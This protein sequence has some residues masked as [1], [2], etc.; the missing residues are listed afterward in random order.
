MNNESANK[1]SRDSTGGLV[2]KLQVVKQSNIGSI[3]SEESPLVLR[4]QIEYWTHTAYYSMGTGDKA[5][6]A[7]NWKS[8]KV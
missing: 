8:T 5:A 6:G 1:V 2:K 7:W 3:P 4:M